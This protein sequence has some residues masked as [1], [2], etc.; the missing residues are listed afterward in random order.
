MAS[1][2]DDDEKLLIRCPGCGQRFKVQQDF[3]NRMVEC[4]VCEHRF[5]IREDVIVR[6]KKFYP[7]EKRHH[8]LSRFQRIPHAQSLSEPMTASAVYEQ[9]AP[10]PYFTPAPPQ[11]IIAGFIGVSVIIIVALLLIFGGD[12]GGPLDGVE[13]IRK[14][15][16]A[17][18]A[19]V[20][21]FVL[22]LYANPNTRRAAALFGGAFASALVALPFFISDGF[23][24]IGEVEDVQALTQMD[25]PDETELDPEQVILNAMRE[26]IGIRPL[27]Q[28]IERLATTGSSAKA[29]GLFLV[30]LQESNR[31]AVRDYMF[32]V[33]SADP[34]SHIY[35]RDENIY[36][37]VLT[38]LEMNIERLAA[39][40]GPLGT[41][42]LIEPELS[43]VEIV[44]DNDIFIESPSEKLINR[45]APEFYELNLREL[46]SI[47]IQRIERAVGRLA[48][49]KPRMLRAD[50]TKRLREL[51][52]ESGV[53]F[54][55]TIARALGS[56]DED[57][58]GAAELATRTA[59]SL[60]QRGATPDAELIALAIEQPS[61]ELIPVVLDLWRGSTLTWESY[62][63]K[64]GPLIEEAMLEEFKSAKGSKKH[65]A[66]RILS[67]VGG[68]SS[69]EALNQ[70]LEGADRELTVIISQALENIAKRQGPDR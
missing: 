63:V 23:T 42:R 15:I 17:G 68:A 48:E 47:D 12:H 36:L 57:S 62:C 43:I 37:F 21:G 34:S 50:I 49:A 2:S 66:A 10:A 20:V 6:I 59:V 38:G 19:G 69:E 45:D 58:S 32:R 55:G 28:E 40:A 39:I 24:N 27:D 33:T 54:H 3:R 11:R 52:D 64:V 25:A 7:G 8:G 31:I 13:R 51:M 70:A 30:G 29:Y 1:P 26:R 67:H 44:V 9:A 4:G 61:D 14:L 41:V 22:L 16:M 65:S 5:H 60:Q 53:T 56:W 46:K 35:P 18:F